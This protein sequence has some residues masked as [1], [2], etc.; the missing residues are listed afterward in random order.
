V[1]RLSATESDAMDQCR[2]LL[3]ASRRG[4][5]RSALLGRRARSDGV[6]LP[7]PLICATWQIHRPFFRRRGNILLIDSRSIALNPYNAVTRSSDRPSG[8]TAK[9]S[10]SSRS[11][12]KT[13]KLLS[14][15]PAPTARP[16]PLAAKR[17]NVARQRARATTAGPP[18]RRETSKT[19]PD[20]GTALE[21]L[22][23]FRQNATA[24]HPDVRRANDG[25][26]RPGLYGV[27]PAASSRA[28][29]RSVSASGEK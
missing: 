7:A 26:S 11:S 6:I 28:Q 27:R 2:A 17:R 1:A 16:D 29:R 14:H 10:A 15:R 22:S 12:P 18:A 13:A 25:S 21:P 5:N 23:P 4:G 24:A 3:S 19:S 20:S 8:G 9:P